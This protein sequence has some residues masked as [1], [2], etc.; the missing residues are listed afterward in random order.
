MF[1]LALL[2]RV[3]EGQ[4]VKTSE[5][6]LLSKSEIADIERHHEPN[7][8]GDAECWLVRYYT[9]RHSD[10]YI[11][12]KH[13]NNS[14]EEG[15]ISNYGDENESAPFPYVVSEDN[16]D[17]HGIGHKA[18]YKEKKA[19]PRGNIPEHRAVHASLGQETNRHEYHERPDNPSQ[20]KR[21]FHST[22]D[23]G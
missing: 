4:E 9:F 6:P 2:S 5:I 8:P 16:E 13:E 21:G 3:R 18:R 12:E 10:R 19:I 20:E 23:K 1:F 11:R 7:D 14:L 17:S 22:K 15:E